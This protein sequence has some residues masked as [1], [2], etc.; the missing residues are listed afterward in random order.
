MKAPPPGWAKA[1]TAWGRTVIGLPYNAAECPDP[2]RVKVSHPHSSLRSFPSWLAV[3][4]WPIPGGVSCF[5]SD[6]EDT[7]DTVYYKL[8]PTNPISFAE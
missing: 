3:G 6:W 8:L 5:F 2:D 4:G 7:T 1:P